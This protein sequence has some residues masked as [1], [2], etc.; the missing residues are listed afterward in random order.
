[1]LS[2]FLSYLI[3]LS[4]PYA[5][6]L[7]IYDR[8]ADL[9][10]SQID[11]VEARAMEEQ[12]RIFEYQLKNFENSLL[13]IATDTRV[14][15][16]V[17]QQNPYATGDSYYNMS[18]LKTYVTS[19]TNS[20]DVMLNIAVVSNI[21]DKIISSQKDYIIN[22]ME[23]FPYDELWGMDR[24]TF[25]ALYKTK[26]ME[27]FFVESNED[28]NRSQHIVMKVPIIVS[29]VAYPEGF[30]IAELRGVD[31]LMQNILDA[32]SP[33]MIMDDKLALLGSALKPEFRTIAKQLETDRVESERVKR[34]SGINYLIKVKPSEMNSWRYIYMINMDRYLK[35]LKQFKLV[36]NVLF[37]VSVVLSLGIALYNSTRNYKPIRHL[38]TMAA[39]YTDEMQNSFQLSNDYQ[40]IESSFK[41]MFEK[42]NAIKQHMKKEEKRQLDWYLYGIIRGWE[43]EEDEFE[44]NRL[45]IVKKYMETED[46]IVL[47]YRLDDFRE[48]F[49]K[50]NPS[51]SIESDINLANF[52]IINV[53][54]ELF[55]PLGAFHIWNLDDR[56]TIPMFVD[57]ELEFEH[58]IE[59][60]H[61]AKAYLYDYFGL[62]GTFVISTVNH[63]KRGI[64]KGF[65]EAMEMLSFISIVGDQNMI[66]HYDEFLNKSGI[67]N[68]HN[69]GDKDNIFMNYIAV[70]DFDAAREI[71][72]SILDE[73]LNTCASFQLLQVK[74]FS[75]IDKMVVAMMSIRLKNA[76]Y[77][78]ITQK[79]FEELMHVSTIPELKERVNVIFNSCKQ[80]RDTMPK[81]DTGDERVHNI[82]DY[83][84]T[85]YRDPNLTVSSIAEYFGMTVSN[86][87]KLMKKELS[88]STLDYLHILRINESK[89]LLL[90]TDLTLSEISE[91]VGYYNYRTLVSRFKK[92]EG[93]TPTQYR[94]NA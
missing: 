56:F 44:S 69:Y 28:D 72:F 41:K 82:A 86:L 37:G 3:I 52:V 84:H 54:E 53:L 2:F 60:V 51:E 59:C 5:I 18:E 78:D 24:G 15:R 40:V 42:M 66:L 27:Y 38:K 88:Y 61:Q 17:S 92:Q 30:L 83:I 19:M 81:Q 64:K 65:E 79:N 71:L 50:K 85:Q 31:T 43:L 46:N 48:V 55:T 94:E 32:K 93:I 26:G 58:Y 90:E 4:I 29:D 75:L 45:K 76:N 13:D 80:L 25:E 67:Q 11:N 87:S 21:N 49:F 39:K 34:I 73:E 47:V 1:M 14:T 68:W 36:V 8:S 63:G 20:S 89:K 7:F 16:F 91:Q 57:S 77:N 12:I 10:A 74:L 9:L 23:T 35:D 33:F 62:V 70:E 22:G 6:G